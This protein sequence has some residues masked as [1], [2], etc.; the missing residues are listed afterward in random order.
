MISLQYEWLSES[1]VGRHVQTV[2]YIYHMWF[3]SRMNDLVFLEAFGPCT[4]FIT[5]II[6]MWYISSMNDQLI[7]E[8]AGVC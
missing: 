2:S 6:C 4:L 3:L 5:H 1:L 7:L 8:T